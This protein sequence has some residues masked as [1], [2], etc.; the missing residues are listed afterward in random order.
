MKKNLILISVFIFLASVSEAQEKN[1]VYCY[2]E[3]MP[4]FPGGEDALIKFVQD[5]ITYPNS[6][7]DDNVSGKVFLQFI[8]DSIGK[9]VDPRIMRGVRTDLDTTC[10]GLIRKMPLWKPGRQNGKPVNVY[11]VLPIIFVLEEADT[12]TEDKIAEEPNKKDTVNKQGMENIREE[13]YVPEI[14][15]TTEKTISLEMV[16]VP[17]DTYKPEITNKPEISALTSIVYPNPTNDIINIEL[18]EKNTV[19]FLLTDLN[20]KIIF[21]GQF[22]EIKNKI[23][24]STQADGVY[25]MTLINTGTKQKS[26]TK[27]IKTK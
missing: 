18:H 4:F 19:I 21:R 11:F 25:V 6:A 13:T 27:V 7:K 5:N 22:N 20:G 24:L 3:K 23:D 12:I 10:L 26:I 2:V 8:V 16:R 17:D 1:N 14:N 9:A 15:D